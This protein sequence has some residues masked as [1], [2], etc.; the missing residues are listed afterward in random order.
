MSAAFQGDRAESAGSQEGWQ[1]G[2]IHRWYHVVEILEVESVSAEQNGT[3][4]LELSILGLIL[5]T[6]AVR[7][8]FDQFRIESTEYFD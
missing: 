5:R 2:L 3:D 4:A 6:F 7:R 1:D 8:H